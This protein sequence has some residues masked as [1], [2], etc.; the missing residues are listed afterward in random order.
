MSLSFDGNGTATSTLQYA[1]VGNM[2][3]AA[4]YAAYG[5]PLTLRAAE[6]FIAFS[7]VVLAML[8]LQ[9]VESFSSMF[10]N[11]YL[12]AK[13]WVPYATLYP[14][15]EA[16]AGI[17]MISG[18]LSW[19]SIPVALFI[20]I[21]PVMVITSFSTWYV[22]SLITVMFCGLDVILVGPTV[23]A[24]SAYHQGS[25]RMNS[26]KSRLTQSGFASDSSISRIARRTIAS[27]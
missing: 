10:L 11:Y 3:L 2:T 22:P 27:S 4:S 13:R 7:M 16:L 1:D 15:A 23:D 25:A 17:L 20:G 6:W 14:F 8:K 26:S 9:N 24:A 12:L 21:A 5:T 19:I 18:A